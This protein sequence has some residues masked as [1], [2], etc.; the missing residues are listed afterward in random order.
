MIL[1]FPFVF[2]LVSISLVVSIQRYRLWDIDILINRTLVYGSLT[3][4]L[5]IAYIASV[6]LLETAFRTVTDQGGSVAI[7]VSTLA[8]AAAFQPLRRWLQ[9]VIDQRFYRR[10]YDAARALAAFSATARDEVDIERLSEALVG[11]VKET[12]QPAHASLWLREK[13]EVRRHA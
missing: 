8:I 9:G 13:E 5:A 12:M 11:A 10:K 6:P 7:V 3:G 4:T 2:A 1:N